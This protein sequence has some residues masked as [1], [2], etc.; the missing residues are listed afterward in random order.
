MSA[1]PLNVSKS[2]PPRWTFSANDLAEN[3]PLAVIEWNPDFKVSLWSQRAVEIFGWTEEEVGGKH[4]REMNFIHEEDEPRVASTVGRF[5]SGELPW[6][7][8]QFRTYRKDRSIAHCMWYCSP[9]RDAEG[10]LLCILTQVLDVTEREI[11]LARLEESERR[12]KATFEQAAVGI[13]HVSTN[14]QVLRA[15][16]KL[17]EIFGYTPQELIIHGF[18]DLTHPDDFGPDLELALKMLQG[19]ISTYSLEKRYLT[20]SGEVIWCNLTVSLV[21]KPDG[22]P[23]YF[24]SV[25]EDISRR[26]R[27]EQERD[28]LL[29]R[30]QQ[31]RSEAEELV[32]RRS[33]ELEAARSALVQAERLA[34]AGQLAAGVGHEINNPLSYVLANQTYA[35][36]ELGRLKVPTPG[37]DMEEVQ[38]ALVQ[39]QLGAERIRDIVRDLRTFA[40]GDPEAMGPVDVQATLEFSISM[41]APQLRQ[42][43]QLVRKYSPA[44]YVHGNES[45]LGQVFLNLLINAAQAI[46]EGN[47]TSHSVTVAVRDGE[48]GWVIVEVSDTGSGIAPEHLQRIFEPFFTTKPVGVGTGLGLSVCHGIVVG[49]GGKIEVDSTL[50]QGTTFRIRLPVATPAPL[51]TPR[52]TS[53]GQRSLTPRR[54]LVIDDDPEVRLALA[55]IVGTPHIVDLADTAREAQHLLLSRKENYDIIFCDLMMPDLTGM[56][57]YESVAAQ[58]PEILPRIV[59]MSAGAFTPRAVAFLERVAARRIDKPFDPIKVRAL[60]EQAIRA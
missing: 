53:P 26:R 2:D 43:A 30:E 51:D 27:A 50:G 19:V 21:R 31:A 60:L 38:R 25:I 54:V 20:R 1:R 46:P 18:A 44:S 41:A 59:F 3:S 4:P 14:G 16:S 23:D 10:N 42:R 39:A 7:V 32:R 56:D 22:M 34:T 8:I 36:E 47:A 45:R 48:P 17:G 52:P 40:R 5:L 49:M 13:A 57:L 37:V 12:F 29:A 15:N 28:A 9:I 33:A 6:G 11:A 58:R 55:R 35:I 24:I